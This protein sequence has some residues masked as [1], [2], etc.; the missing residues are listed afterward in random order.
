[1]AFSSHRSRVTCPICHHTQATQAG[2]RVS[3][4]VRCYRCQACLIISQSG[5]YVRD[6]LNDV[7]SVSLD[8]FHRRRTPQ[9]RWGK[10]NHPTIVILLG[11]VMLGG[12][13]L[14]QVME[15]SPR[16]SLDEF[17]AS[18]VRDAISPC[19]DAGK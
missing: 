9:G 16:F 5:H 19:D 15:L 10:F 11:S 18:L 3:G 6:P 12:L 7:N 17:G 2:S 14:S 13:A 1:M 4:L 8:R